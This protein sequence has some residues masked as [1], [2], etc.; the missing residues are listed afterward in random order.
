MKDHTTRKLTELVDNALM[1]AEKLKTVLEVVLEDFEEIPGCPDR[2]SEMT[3]SYI[4]HLQTLCD[5]GHDYISQINPLLNEAL[6]VG[7][8]KLQKEREGKS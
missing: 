8:L 7:N 2:V 6:K 1:R 4:Y 3:S 5:I